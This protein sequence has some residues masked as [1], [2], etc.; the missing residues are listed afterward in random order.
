MIFEDKIKGV[1]AK[2]TGLKKKDIEIKKPFG[3][4]EK[5]GDYCF[6]SF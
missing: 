2:V 6:D 1:I 3:M 5:F 4:A